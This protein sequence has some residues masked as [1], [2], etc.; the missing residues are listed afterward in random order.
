[1]IEL[2]P[3]NYRALRFR[4]DAYLR[5]GKHAEAVADFDKALK[6]RDDDD[7]LLNNFAWVLATSPKDDVRDGKRALDL[8]TK[9]AE[10]TTYNVP[11]ILS[12][13]AAAYAETGDFETAKKWSQKAVEL[14]EDEETKKQLSAELKSYEEGKPVRELQEDEDKTP[15]APAPGDHT[16][17]PPSAAPAPSRTA[18]F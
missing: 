13:L 4:G 2:D 14:G 17:A 11:H 5:I 12:T 1:V 9:A 10:K 7:G 15:A 3:D 8:A 6:L 18:D 16:F